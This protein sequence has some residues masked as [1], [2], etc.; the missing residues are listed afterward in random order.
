MIENLQVIPGEAPA[1]VVI[2]SERE[3]RS[4]TEML[5][6][7]VAVTHG[8]I[9][10]RISATNEA[11]QPAPFGGE[12]TTVTNADISVSEENNPSSCLNPVLICE[13]LLT[14]LM[15]WALHPHL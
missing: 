9:S 1:R 2:N 12:T 3:R 8:T 14:Q 11:S 4:L 6:D 7:A 13:R 10:V 5:K 15:K